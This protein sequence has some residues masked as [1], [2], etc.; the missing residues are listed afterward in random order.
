MIKTENIYK[1]YPK[2]EVSI[3]VLRGISL[4]IKRGEMVSIMGP[5]GS[6]KSTLLGIMGC[7]NKPTSG[8]VKI[9]HV[10]VTTM[11]NRQLAALRNSKI[12]FVFQKF[13]LASEDSA[14]E[15]V[16]LPMLYNPLLTAKKRRE[17]AIEILQEMGLGERLNHTPNKLSG[18][19]CQRVAIARALVNEP[20]I[21]L[22]DE[23][24]GSLDSKTSKEIMELIVGICEEKNITLVLVTHDNEVA[25]MTDR[26]IRI[27]DGLIVSDEG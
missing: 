11:N 18:G 15:N 13:H 24:T 2:E 16:E 8:M 4:H 6:G 9:D 10:D 14:V 3:T 5:S 17:L 19:E 7:L 27:K 23:P 12:G 20:R 1:I 22:A 25:K 26:L 21:I